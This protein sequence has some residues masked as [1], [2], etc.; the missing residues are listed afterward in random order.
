MVKECG[1]DEHL[2]SL[3][4]DADSP[5]NFLLETHAVFVGLEEDMVSRTTRFW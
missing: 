4:A 5:S 1:N 3:L 2:F